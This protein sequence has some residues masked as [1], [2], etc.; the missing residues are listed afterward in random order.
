MSD[1]EWATMQE[2]LSRKSLETLSAYAHR[3]FVE[4]EITPA[5]MRVVVDVLTDITQGLVPKEVSDVIYAVRKEL[6]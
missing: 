4:G 6:L 1:R 5:E 2:E 3:H